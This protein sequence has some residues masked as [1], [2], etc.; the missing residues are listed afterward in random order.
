MSNEPEKIEENPILKSIYNF[1]LQRG[2]QSNDWD[3]R[4]YDIWDL[5]LHVDRKLYQL[6]SIPAEYKHAHVFRFF[7]IATPA[8][9]A[10]EW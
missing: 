4:A 6:T 1:S 9:S 10:S 7:D 2:T 3:A 8:I 5:N